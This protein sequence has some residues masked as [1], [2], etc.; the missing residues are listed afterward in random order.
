M[1]RCAVAGCLRASLRS[2]ASGGSCCRLRAVRRTVPAGARCIIWPLHSPSYSSQGFK[3]F[4]DSRDPRTHATWL[5]S[6]SIS[7]FSLSL[8]AQETSRRH[9]NPSTLVC[10]LHQKLFDR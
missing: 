3:A 9:P 2:C 8:S 6:S 1:H 7:P 10:S 5:S 4:N